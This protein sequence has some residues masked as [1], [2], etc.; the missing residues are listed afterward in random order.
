MKKGAA[1][2]FFC[3]PGF[4]FSHRAT[5]R[6]VMVALMFTFNCH[7]ATSEPMK[8]TF[9]AYPGDANGREESVSVDVAVQAGGARR[10]TLMSTQVQRDGAPQQRVVDERVYAPRVNSPSDL[11]DALFAMALDDARLNSVNE[12]RDSAHNGGQPIACRC[13]Q[14][15]ESWNYVWTRDLAM[16]RISPRSDSTGNAPR[17]RCCSRSA[18]WRR[19]SVRHRRW[20]STRMLHSAHR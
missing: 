4:T 1:A 11:F 5:A 13:F 7:P 18:V 19:H 17:P 8:Q 12:I 10:F 16:P 2:P 15:G 14:T 9:P 3:V 6:L 20:P